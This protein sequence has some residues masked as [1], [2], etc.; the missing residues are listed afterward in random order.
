MV[1]R[2]SR[3]VAPIV[4]A[5]ALASAAHAAVDDAMLATR[6]VEAARLVRDGA[7]ER[8]L[9]ILEKL[10]EERRDS[11]AVHR[12]IALLALDLDQ[13]D[14]WR[15]TFRARVR[16]TARDVGAGV[17]LAILERARGRRSEAHRLL[18]T[19]LSADG[20][21]PLLAP[22]LLDTTDNRA[23]LLSWMKRRQAVLPHDP[24]FAALRARMLLAVGRVREARE[25]VE[26]AIS[27]DPEHPDLLLLGGRIAWASGDSRRA[28]EAARIAGGFLAGSNE[29]PELRVPRRT[30]LVRLLT[31]C[32]ALEEAQAVL[33]ATGPRLG[34]GVGR[35][36]ERRFALARAELRLAARRPL[37]ALALLGSAGDGDPDAGRDLVEWAW[38]VRARALALAG[39]PAPALFRAVTGP[40]P[41][42]LALADRS[43][44]LGALA[45][46]GPPL[47]ADDDAPTPA[48]GAVLAER[49]REVADRL[50]REGL[51][52]R[53]A[54]A[55][56]LAAHLTGEPPAVRGESPEL[57]VGR[58]LLA[59]ARALHDERPDA[60]AEHAAVGPLAMVGAP[61]SLTAALRLHGARASILT[62]RASDAMRLAR[63]GVL[64]LEEADR[65]GTA[66]PWELRPVT[67]PPDDLGLGL[68]GL[69]FRAALDAGVPLSDAASQLLRRLGRL[70]R[71]WSILE[72]T[73]RSDPARIAGHLRAGSCLIVST[74][75][76]EVPALAIG[77]GGRLAAAPVDRILD[78]DPCAGEGPVF[79]LGPA[80]AG[81][82]LIAAPDPERVLVRAIAP[83]P[84]R[85]RVLPEEGVGGGPAEPEAPFAPF[86]KLVREAAGG[87][88]AGTAGGSPDPPFLL[89]GAGLA[90]AHA[91]MASGV[92]ATLPGAGRARWVG[93]E[94]LLAG[95]LDPA[96]CLIA[97]GVRRL[98]A[99]ARIDEGSWVLAE[100]AVLSGRRF[101]LVS[102]RPLD[103]S[104]RELLA[105]MAARLCRS[106][107]GGIGELVE[108][109]PELARALALWSA[110][111]EIGPE[112]GGSAWWWLAGGGLAAL[113]LVLLA[114][115]LH[116]RGVWPRR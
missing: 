42:G 107:L 29:V 104:E 10:A 111:G 65:I 41:G 90:L 56:L 46:A 83:E 85:R 93:P 3:G 105:G 37:E 19:V 71:R 63:D 33:A 40:L 12:A 14:A 115:M 43:T 95:G 76:P 17:G 1:G 106:P 13:A 9:A 110:P 34:I 50:A 68:A 5:L 114:L 102:R 18:L 64:D 100:G 78:E 69:E 8:G 61:R 80:D 2:G 51:E 101:L 7:P 36:L 54:R 11:V 109:A 60:A 20:R 38:S 98:P 112:N 15:R 66:T 116:R 92:L 108:R 30:A 57:T 77:P 16:R 22:L 48:P 53:G 59:A 39:T 99:G 31:S 72:T 35:D 113:G 58:A 74:A 21:D 70:V 103:E 47:P 49:V 26:T 25:V 88:D 6:Y 55:A 86:A 94:E 23:G 79:W 97:T 87:G 45:L 27:R 52:P 67:G 89:T 73:W 62:G 82:G 84:V 81:D 24:D 44:A 96:E 75:E 32:G 4:L 28:C 91:P